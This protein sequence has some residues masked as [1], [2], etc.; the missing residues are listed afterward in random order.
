MADE[1]RGPSSLPSRVYTRR[2]ASPP[3][4][5][6]AALATYGA[7]HVADVV[8]TGVMSAR[9]A[10]IDRPV[11]ALAGAAVTVRVTP[12]DFRMIPWAVDQLGRGDVLVIDGGGNRDRAIWGDFVGARA[13]ALGCAAVVVD[14]A[15]R[16]APGLARLALP[17]FARTLAARGPT[18]SGRGEVNVPVS[19]GGVCVTP[20]DLIVADGEGIV[21]VPAGDLDQVVELVR[22]RQAR[23]P[24]PPA[25]VTRADEAW[26][27]Y[28]A[29][30]ASDWEG[31]EI[32]ER[33]WDGT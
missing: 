2:P 14:G 5:A 27:A 23:A 10:P 15:A 18:K 13:A 22:E 26:R 16:D 33:R 11:E 28:L 19:C 7:C 24:G 3:A 31:P 9:I 17:V 6:L 32:H 8:G 12:G 29:A 20:G 4:A 25:D 21:V 1:R 30:G